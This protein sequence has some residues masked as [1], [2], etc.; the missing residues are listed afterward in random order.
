MFKNEKI[1][2]IKGI[3]KLEFLFYQNMYIL[4]HI[5]FYPLIHFDKKKSGLVV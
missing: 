5:I 1:N 2:Y 4:F 3:L